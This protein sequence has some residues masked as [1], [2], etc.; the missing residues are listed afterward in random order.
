MLPTLPVSVKSPA[1][2]P[3]LSVTLVKDFISGHLNLVSVESLRKTRKKRSKHHTSWRYHGHLA[4]ICCNEMFSNLCFSL[5]S[6]SDKEELSV[7]L[8]TPAFTTLFS[9]LFLW[10]FRVPTDV[11]NN[12]LLYVVKVNSLQWFVC[13]WL[14]YLM[15][16]RLAIYQF[17]LLK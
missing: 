10:I 8:V 6:F 5:Q 9:S 17:I 14:R 4:P 12:C 7:L 11:F 1:F 2:S 15:I 16:L 13:L 3:P